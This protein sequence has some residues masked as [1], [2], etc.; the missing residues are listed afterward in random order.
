LK[1]GNIMLSAEG[2][3]KV[4]D[5]GLAKAYESHATNVSLTNSPTLA[6]IA[7][8]Q[9]GMILGTAAYMSPE[10]AK[11]RAVDRRTD[12]FALGCILYEML[13]GKRAFDGEDVTDILGAV[14]RIEP[15]W[16]RLPDDLPP[17]V[18][19]LLRLCLE[20]N[21]KN[22]R[23]DATDVRLDIEHVLKEPV[24]ELQAAAI[25]IPKRSLWIHA[26][27]VAAALVLGAA[28]A[29]LAVWKYKPAAALPVT[30]FS[31]LLDQGQNFT[32]TGRNLVA[33][34]PDGSQMVYSA[35]ARLYHRRLSELDA[36]PIPGTETWNG[37]L[38]PVFSPD[39][40]SIAFFASSDRTLK[41]IAVSGGA[42]VTLCPV[43]DGIFG[44]SWGDD[45][46]AFGTG[47]KGIL[48]VNENGGDPVQLATVEPGEVAHG[49]Q[50]LPGGEAVLYTVRKDADW[51]KAK[52]FV[53]SLK[54]GSK[55]ELVIDG[56][57]D[58]RYVSTGHIVYAYGGSLFAIPF[59]LG[60]LKKTSGPTPI[61][62]GVRRAS[63]GAT[64]S[65]HFSFSN[66]GTLI[67]VPG[68][69]SG[70]A[71]AGQRTLAFLDR[72]GT[73][74][75]RIKMQTTQTRAYAFARVSP[76][77]RN[78]VA[79]ST[80]DETPNVWIIDIAG[81]AGPRQLTL[82]GKNQFP[83]WSHDGQRIA[84]QSDREGDPGIFW[85]KADGTGVAERLTKPEQGIAH[86][87][88]SFSPDG[89][90][91]SYSAVKGAD[92]A[93]WILSLMD[94][95]STVFATQ[96][97]AY[98]ARSAF[99]PDG[100][101]LAY[102]SNETGQVQV[103]AQ[104]F[105]ATGAK[106]PVARG[107]QPV[108]SLDGRE[109]YYNPAIGQLAVIGIKTRPSF[110]FGDPLAFSTSG[111][112]STNPSRE[113]RPWDISPD[114]KQLIGVAAASESGTP[115]DPTLQIRVVLNWFTDLK[116]RVHVK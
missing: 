1:P 103:F 51:D 34:S 87:P 89:K 54:T 50:I 113:T 109:I 32:N 77:D 88:D 106:Y 60:Q 23:S 38:N 49:P 79:V 78:L 102:Q 59:D 96:A 4:L 56:G 111:L 17:G 55:R 110:S 90:S 18:R 28:I 52:I 99:S 61:L 3:V 46:I 69:T 12:I 66:N 70:D 43:I 35:N 105:P 85:Q 92:S 14:L 97:A 75:E 33:I 67:Y 82:G 22:R 81:R 16:G 8:T 5:F 65:A 11:G 19:N 72:K 101:W 24:R 48:R 80:D 15:D 116:E 98:I 21:P 29:G 93:V 20:K 107:G 37:V 95:K 115:A 53:Q 58:G 94:K 86:I 7:G 13:T 30:R 64:G 10:Q 100:Q 39:G 31:I 25:E 68:P 91:L 114:G 42:S 74:L 112:R 40:Q 63:G 83:V 44:L 47:A 71:I 57:S 45:G 84:F 62:E 76:T 6:S 41:K 9:V 36:R 2:K 108:W 26:V 73:A 104:P 27:P